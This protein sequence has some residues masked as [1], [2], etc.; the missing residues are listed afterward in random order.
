MNKEDVVL[1]IW[2]IDD[3]LLKE[4]VD[5]D[6]IKDLGRDGC[7]YFVIG[8]DG[9]CWIDQHLDHLF[10][11]LRNIGGGEATA[12]D[13]GALQVYN[14]TTSLTGLKTD[15]ESKGFEVKIKRA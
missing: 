14:C 13:E 1:E 10:P 4:E 7:D 11:E 2:A 6:Y 15:L 3:L 5:P 12:D 8:K 9:D